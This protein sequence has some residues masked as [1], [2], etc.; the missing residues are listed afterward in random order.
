MADDLK[1]VHPAFRAGI[2]TAGRALAHEG[3]LAAQNRAEIFEAA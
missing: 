1:Q 2:K 3:P